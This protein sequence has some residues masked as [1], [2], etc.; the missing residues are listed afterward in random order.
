MDLIINYRIPK[1]Q[2]LD[3]FLRKRKTLLK[4][5]SL[6]SHSPTCPANPATLILYPT[7]TP[8]LHAHFGSGR[9]SSWGTAS[10]LGKHAPF[11]SY[12][13]SLQKPWPWRG[14]G[15]QLTIKSPGVRRS[16]NWELSAPSTS[17][18]I[19]RG[20]CLVW[21]SPHLASP[22]L[23]QPYLTL[24]HLTPPYLTSPSLLLLR[25]N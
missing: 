16:C 11:K 23:T 9:W 22:L 2:P 19:D 17:L 6:F 18:I 1:E 15:T 8:T 12:L 4:G 13:V 24:P 3:S 10:L 20:Q 21:A 7:C 14:F 25:D 5:F